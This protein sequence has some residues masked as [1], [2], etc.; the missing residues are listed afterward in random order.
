MQ[1]RF[2]AQPTAAHQDAQENPPEWEWE[3]PEDKD[4]PTLPPELP[5][6]QEKEDMILQVS[7]LPHSGQVCG[8]SPSDAKTNCSKQV[9][10]VLQRYS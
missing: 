7:F 8:V 6:P 1:K 10:Q 3:H 9:P 2:Q 5:D 4:W